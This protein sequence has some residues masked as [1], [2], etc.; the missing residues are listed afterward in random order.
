MTESP[1]LNVEYVLFDMDG[2]LLI[3]TFKL[4]S[5]HTLGLLIDSERI[6]TIVTST[7]ID[8]EA[9]MYERLFDR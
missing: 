6:Y 9:D 4:F 5:D 3:N 8:V 1:K 2:L 7:S